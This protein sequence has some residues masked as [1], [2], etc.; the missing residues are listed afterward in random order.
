ML[1]H[2]TALLEQVRDAR[3]LRAVDNGGSQD[4]TMWAVDF[5]MAMRSSFEKLTLP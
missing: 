4:I 3:Y 2:F 5:T 1:E